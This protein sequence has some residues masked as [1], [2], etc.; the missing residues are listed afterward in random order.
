M[1][2]IRP[3]LIEQTV[4]LTRCGVSAPRIA[5]QLGVTPRTV[6]RWRL[7]AGISEGEARHIAQ[8]VWEEARR[9]LDDGASYGEVARTLG[10][11]RATVARHFPGEGWSRDQTIR[12]M[13]ETR[14]L[15]RALKK[16]A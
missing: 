8:E 15:N 9:I 4:E 14:G 13:I 6:T 11:S 3:E 12:F 2:N 1:T 10:V 5:E 7:R 16:I